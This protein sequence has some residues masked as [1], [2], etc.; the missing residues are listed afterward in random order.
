MA[1]SAEKVVQALRTAL[2]DNDTLRER[3]RDLADAAREPIAIVGMGCRYPG[4]VRS[5][6]Q[7]WRLVADG[8]DAVGPF[9]ADR[10]WD[11]DALFDPDPDRPGTLYTAEGGFLADADAFDPDFFGIS[12]REALAMDPQQRV[13]LEI[14]WEAVERANIDPHSLRGSATAVFVG[15]MATDYAA[16]LPAVPP[17]VEGFLGT[18]TSSSVASGR[19][20]YELGLEGPALTLDTACSSSLVALHLACQALRRR[21]CGL[22][23]AGGVTVMA[24]PGLFIGFSRQRGL[25]R[26]GRCRSFADAADGAGFGEGAGL[27]LLERLSDARRA[28]RL[29]LAVLRGSAVNSDGASN[30]LTAPN[31]PSQQR[32][33]RAALADARLDPAQVDAVEGHGTGT[34]L[35]D[36]IEAQALLATY[37]RDR[38]PRRPLWLGSLKSNVSHT[39]AAAGVGGV[40]KMVM[41]MR[42]G[43]LPRTL[44]V[45]GPSRTVDWTAGAVR[46]L[47]KAMPWPADDRP[48]RAGVSSFGVSGTNA[49]LIVE[50]APADA[51]AAG[52]AGGPAGGPPDSPLAPAA[53]APA[54]PEGADAVVPVPLVLSAHD[55][56][57]LR[58]QAERLRARLSGE[59][60]WRPAD[61][62]HTLVAARARHSHRAVAVGSGP[63][64]LLGALDAVADGRP[65]PLVATAV[66]DAAR[67]PVFVFSGQGS[68]WAGMALELAESSPVFR[69][70]LDLCAQALAPHVDW[71]LWD[72]LRGVPGAPGLDRAGVVQPALF[73]VMTATA[74]LWRTFGVRPAAVVG[75]SQGEIAAACV[76]GAIS[77]PDAALAVARRG[78]ALE[79]ELGGRGGMVAVALPRARADTLLAPWD[80]RLAVAAVNASDSIVVS[81]ETVA[82]GELVERCAADGTRTRPIAVDIASHSPAVERVR[83]RLLAGLGPVRPVSVPTPFYSTVDGER[84]DTASLDASYWLRNTR[85]TVEFERAVRALLA[86]GHRTFVEI[87]PHP[88]L[89]AAIQQTALDAGLDLAGVAGAGPDAVVTVA[90]GRRGAG[91]LDQFLLGMAAAHVHGVPVD[92]TAAFTGTGARLVDLPTYPFR[93]RRFWL[94]ADRGIGGDASS[95][96]QAAADHPLLDAAVDWPDAGPAVLTGRLSARTHPWIADHA[97]TGVVLLPGTALVELAIRAGDQVGLD[98]VEELTLPAPLIVAADTA[99]HL[100][101]LVGAVDSSG[102]RGIDIRSR[103]EPSPVAAAEHGVDE[104]GVDERNPWT[105]HATG[106]LSRRAR[107]RPNVD[108]DAAGAWPP[109]GAQ[110]VDLE[111]FYERFAESGFAYGPAFRGLRAL[112]RR[113]AELFAEV[114]L[115]TEQR[116]DVGRFGLHPAL[117]DAAF[118]AVALLGEPVAAGTLGRLPFSWSD[119]QLQATGA[120]ALR[121]RLTPREPDV[122]SLLATDAAGRTVVSVGALTLRP[123]PAGALGQAESAAR[124]ARLAGTDSLFRIRWAPMSTDLP[125]RRGAA[126]RAAAVLG[127]THDGL[128]HDGSARDRSAHDG[129]TRDGFVAGLAATGTPVRSAGELRDLTAPGPPAPDLVFTIIPGGDPDH[130]VPAAVRAATTAAL[131]LLHSWLAD[132]RFAASRLVFV[133]RDLVAADGSVDGSAG[134]GAP[135]RPGWSLAAAAVRGLVRSAQSEHPDRFVL[136]D[137][138]DHVESYA[139]LPA[140]L[141]TDEPRLAVREGMVRAE[142]LARLTAAVGGAAGGAAPVWAT[143]GTVLVT[144]ATGTLGRL[145]VRHLAATHGVRRFLLLSRHGI[146]ADGAVEFLG[147]LADLGVDATLTAC[148]VGDRDALAGALA[149]VAAEYPLTGVVHTAGAVDDGVVAALTPARI[150][151]VL[152]PKANAAWYLH[153]L[154]RGADLTAFV[155][156]SS[157]AGVFGSAGQGNYAAANAVLDALAVQRRAAGLPATSLAWGMWEQRSTLTAHLG[158]AD[159]ARMSAG[160]TR[161]L[162]T[163]QGLALF[164]AAL[165]ADVPVALPIQ[166]TP[167]ALRRRTGRPAPASAAGERAT[168]ADVVPPLLRGLVDGPDPTRRGPTRRVVDAAVERGAFVSRL[169]GLG[170]PEREAILVELVRADVA[171]VLGHASTDE[172]T[173]HRSFL[174]LGFDSLTGIGLRNRLADATGLRLRPTV[175][176]D[177]PTPVDLARHLSAELAGAVLDDGRAATGDAPSPDPAAGPASPDPAA[178]VNAEPATALFRQA[179]AAGRIKVGL[180]LLRDAALL[181]PMFTGVDGLARIAEPVRIARGPARPPVIC[182]SSF[183]ALGGVH[184]FLRFASFFRGERD[185]SVVALPGFEDDEPLPTSVHALIDLLAETVAIHGAAA[186]PVL[187]GASSGG[188]LAVAAARAL[189]RRGLH[190]AA[191]VLLDTYLASDQAIA[192]FQDVLVG[193]MFEREGAFVAMNDTRLTAMGW[194]CDLFADWAPEPMSTPVL[195]VRASEPLVDVAPEDLATDWR[196]SWPNAHTVLDVPGNHFTIGE[197]HAEVTSGVV[198][199]WLQNTLGEQA[200]HNAGG[201]PASRALVNGGDDRTPTKTKG[202]P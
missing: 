59:G 148:D 77:L 137:I 109:T 167:T 125:A 114:A 158:A 126:P 3:N 186:P 36:P 122:V 79:A 43:L 144:G 80:G 201:T 96:G 133:T 168:G 195:L 67:S 117:L 21:E 173:A 46:L 183:V 74:E 166:L 85:Q 2:L 12:P 14:A 184:Q 102:R 60:S 193:G 99:I 64:E 176:F 150:G 185:V 84:I 127:R 128:A 41:A 48:R 155:L 90:S 154:T 199:D 5:P 9:P 10:G 75:H 175:V 124:A 179:T 138:D 11:V 65:T 153:E 110:P 69:S 105:T 94:E 37:G 156:Y 136:V 198:R 141:T 91:G 162:S 62:G 89:T 174:E 25:S 200:G 50:Q 187:L 134:A 112:W 93:R 147:Q 139:I 18:G 29:V 32:V 56:E 76:A 27:L 35:G 53:P 170:E 58:A 119:V 72:V 63:D 6:E 145:V 1:T 73:A 70:R 8:V 24:S 66:A 61:V 95:V 57:T 44:H 123:V 38:D 163:G 106:V 130:D 118:H 161:P 142:R 31:G 4:G 87:G 165:A 113:D 51:P 129:L 115:P 30:G 54:A 131:A 26:D 101:V 23:L 71:S 104:H 116:T 182:F 181:R 97:V 45:D 100:Q 68:Q 121:V 196:S 83:D 192:Q 164:D 47:T 111:G 191:V 135:R 177:H 160:G 15:V 19:I 107:T 20:A 202:R 169:A 120:T 78:A 188:L 103:A 33:I 88:V 152:R 92:W 22:A 28:G 16:R 52:R 157:A 82:L 42:H 178:G 189:E 190:P 197:Q 143:H 172:V 55:D 180:D 140:A 34:T 149:S 159:L 146:R 171:A 194:Y 108:S 7:L 98:Q 132:E 86:D 13:L 49:H 151:A 17:D 39:Q 40:I 81:G